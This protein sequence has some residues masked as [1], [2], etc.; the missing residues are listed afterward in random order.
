MRPGECLLQRWSGARPGAVPSVGGPEPVLYLPTPGAL[1]KGCL[2]SLVNPVLMHH[3]TLH[4][5]YPLS[6]PPR[7][8]SPTHILFGSCVFD[9]TEQKPHHGELGK[10]CVC[11]TSEIFFIQYVSFMSKAPLS[12]LKGTES[13]GM[14][15]LPH[16]N[17]RSFSSLLLRP[18]GQ[19]QQSLQSP[20]TEK[21][22]NR[23][24]RVREQLT[25][26]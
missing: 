21:L 19:S 24:V 25:N 5:H 1:S 22:T 26:Y 23:L 2:I 16:V 13:R 11:L 15:T 7:P 9:S 3:P 12:P 10:Q 17:L 20:L 4:S 8:V 6:L 18:D 14:K